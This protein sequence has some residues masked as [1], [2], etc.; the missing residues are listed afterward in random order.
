MIQQQLKEQEENSQRRGPMARAKQLQDILKKRR[1][2]RCLELFLQV[3]RLEKAGELRLLIHPQTAAEA[4]PSTVVETKEFEERHRDFRRLYKTLVVDKG[5]EAPAREAIANGRTAADAFGT[6]VGA[7][8]IFDLVKQKQCLDQELE[9]WKKHRSQD[10][11]LLHRLLDDLLAAYSPQLWQSAAASNKRAGGMMHDAAAVAGAAPAW[12]YVQRE[13]LRRMVEVELLPVLKREIREELL[14]RAQQVVILRCRELLEWRLDT[15]PLR[16]SPEQIRQRQQQGE[17]ED[18]DSNGAG[19]GGESR[20]R[21][22]R[23]RGRSRG[24]GGDTGENSSDVDSVFGDAQSSESSESESSSTSSADE[25]DDDDDGDDELSEERRRQKAAKRQRRLQRKQRL[26]DRKRRLMQEPALLDVV[27]FITETI[28]HGVPEL[29]PANM[30]GL[31]AAYRQSRR[32]GSHVRVHAMLVNTWGEMEEYDRFEFLLNAPLPDAKEG[33][34]S[35]ASSAAAALALQNASNGTGLADLQLQRPFITPE[36]KRAQQDFERLL[37]LFKERWVDAAVVGVRDR[38][39]L[40]LYLILKQRLIPKLKK[41]HQPLF[42]EL[43][44]ADV[45]IIW[46]GSDRVPDAL[47]QKFDREALMVSKGLPC[48]FR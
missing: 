29:G 26:L 13:I 46:S 5:R 2:T 21:R 7:S 28:D 30:G 19:E 38:F 41:K 4:A 1:D 25:D 44:K 24:G 39:A 48:H 31:G 6:G 10:A 45:P 3:H 12:L 17:E 11:F 43:A 9:A 34:D 37:K 8:L 22:S 33:E 47:R 40:L 15:Q 27:A 36:Q 32:A 18:D 35:S 23:R 16:P 14:H 20:G 42:L